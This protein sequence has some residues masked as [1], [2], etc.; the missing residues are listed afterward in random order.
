MPGIEIED[1]EKHYEN[2]YEQRFR[3]SYE[4]CGNN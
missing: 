1:M 2:H 4:I 3:N